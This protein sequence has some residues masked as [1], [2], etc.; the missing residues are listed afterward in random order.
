MKYFL[1]LHREFQADESD[2]YKGKGS[3]FWY[4]VFP[5]YLNQ[6]PAQALRK[7][8]VK[9][10]LQTANEIKPFILILH[11]GLKWGPGGCFPKPGPLKAI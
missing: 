1:L 11:S 3:C 8:A 5:E 2:I 7:T 9:K 10:I 6:D 4:L